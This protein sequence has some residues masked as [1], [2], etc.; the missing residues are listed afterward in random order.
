MSDAFALESVKE[1]QR[2]NDEFNSHVQQLYKACSDMANFI[3]PQKDLNDKLFDD[4]S[5]PLESWLHD[6]IDL[7]N[8]TLDKY[9]KLKPQERLSKPKFDKN[10]RNKMKKTL[11]R[12]IKKSSRK[13]SKKTSKASRKKSKSKN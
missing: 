13:S 11:K 10:I 6:S 9:G 1:F 2:I 7:I 3:E 5:K 8:K 12:T 4:L